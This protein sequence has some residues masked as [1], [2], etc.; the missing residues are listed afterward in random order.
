MLSLDFEEYVASAQRAQD[1]FF[2]DR[3]ARSRSMESLFQKGQSAAQQ[4]EGVPDLR[5]LQG[6]S[7]KQ[8]FE[9]AILNRRRESSIDQQSFEKYNL[10]SQ[11]LLKNSVQKNA[12]ITGAQELL[13][14]SSNQ[15][16]FLD[17]TSRTL[18][19]PGDTPEASTQ[20]ALGSG[21][22]PAPASGSGQKTKDRGGGLPSQ[23]AW[24]A[25]TQMSINC[26]M[27][28]G[29]FASDQMLAALNERVLGLSRAAIVKEVGSNVENID[30][31]NGINLPV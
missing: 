26:M 5:D 11:G 4:R 20:E 2:A 1:Q 25:W 30:P 23:V 8:H 29:P 18:P 10:D 21:T 19:R 16:T 27:N 28:C 17:P 3:I 14:S 22:D 15:P 31:L 13:P 12:A 9:Q 7:V 6:A 24:Q